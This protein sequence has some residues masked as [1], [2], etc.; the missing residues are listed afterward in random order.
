L[1]AWSSIGLELVGKNGSKKSRAGNREKGGDPGGTLEEPS[2][3]KR[4]ED[5]KFMMEGVNPLEAYGLA[6]DEKGE[7]SRRGER[8]LPG[9]EPLGEKR[10]LNLV[11]DGGG[12]TEAECGEGNRTL[13]YGEKKQADRV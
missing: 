11:L 2:G 7:G 9:I 4:G 8:V 6:Q 10:A 5:T 12:S 1:L 3:T 13:L